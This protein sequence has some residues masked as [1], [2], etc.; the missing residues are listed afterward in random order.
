VIPLTD[1]FTLP[2]VATSTNR[3]FPA[4][5]PELSVTMRD[6]PVPAFFACWTTAGPD[7]P[8]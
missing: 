6:V 1:P 8:R 2:E 3:Q 7:R 5:V 4:V